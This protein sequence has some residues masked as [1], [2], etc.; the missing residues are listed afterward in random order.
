MYFTYL[1]GWSQL[2]KFYYG[3]R[4]KEGVQESSVGTTYFSS[5]KYVH[6]FIEQYGNPDVIQIRKRF[7]SKVKAKS[8]EE[9]VIRRMKCI[10]SDMWLNRGN[11]NS[12]KEI[13]MTEDIA[14]KISE[15]KRKNSK[16]RSKL[17]FY[18]NGTS[19]KGFRE[20]D[21]IPD[22]WVVGRI[23]S[24]SQKEWYA[25]LNEQ[26][27]TPEKRKETGKKVS[28]TTKGKPKP[29]GFGQKITAAQLGKPKPW[30]A[31]DNNPAKDPEV[32]KKISDK[33]KGCKH[34]TDGYK[35]IFVKEGTQPEG[36][37]QTSIY[38]FKKLHESKQQIS[39]SNP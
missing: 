19:N 33:K 5:S 7:Q 9:K 8:W 10:L 3:V 23:A 36:F 20:G 35:L 13:V 37:Y 17:V 34:Y 24:K 26:I 30:N 31:G 1:L 15:V 29:E 27:L 11:N 32:R 2:N 18:N 39:N 38:H 6:K 14:K 4:Y 12:F 25:K 22:G 28:A 21:V 16:T